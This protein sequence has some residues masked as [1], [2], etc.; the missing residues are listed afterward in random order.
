M[1]ATSYKLPKHV[2]PETVIRAYLERAGNFALRRQAAAAVSRQAKQLAR[3]VP[4]SYYFLFRAHGIRSG[5]RDT[6]VLACRVRLA[7]LGYPFASKLGRLSIILRTKR[8]DRPV[9]RE[10]YTHICSDNK[11]LS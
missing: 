10:L 5:A 9:L 1:S 4:I 11:E 8:S 2:Q 7:P 3:V 6:G